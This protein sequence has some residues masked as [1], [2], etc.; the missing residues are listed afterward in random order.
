M[1]FRHGLQ[2]QFLMLIG[3]ALL[4]VLALMALLLERQQAIQA[5]VQ[6]L[7]RE[8][9]ETVAAEVVRRRGEV[10]GTAVSWLVAVNHGSGDAELPA[11]GVELQENEK[12]PQYQQA[13][14]VAELNKRRN[15]DRNG[16]MK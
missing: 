8:A 5:E 10:A 14:K 1:S 7:G 11:A 15:A 6:V 3:A 13:L 16:R 4:V 2:A 12:T 9:M